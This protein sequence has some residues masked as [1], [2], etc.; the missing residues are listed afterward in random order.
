M[1]TRVNVNKHT[2]VLLLG[3]ADNNR[4]RKEIVYANKL[5]DVKRIFG[6]SSEL[7]KAYQE[8]SLL[9]APAIFL[10]NC[11]EN[12]DYLEITE[13]LRANDF[14]YIVP[15]SLNLSDE[16]DEPK[17]E[18]RISYIEYMLEQIGHINESVFIVTD[19]HADLYEDMDAFI[20]SMNDIAVSFQQKIE[21]AINPENIIFVANNLVNYEHANIPLV[22]SLVI[23]K[24]NQY[25]VLDFGPALFEID[26]FEDIG[27][28]AYFQNHVVRSTTVENLLNFR[29]IS[30]TKI[31]FI[32]RICKIIKRQLNFNE[33]IGR[34]YT[35]YRRLGVETKLNTYLTALLKELIYDYN[36]ISVRGYRSPEPLSVNIENVFE[37][38]PVNCLEKV[39][40]SNTVEVA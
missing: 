33:F 28:W 13:I 37:I 36:I 20:E 14:A 8:L 21:P 10:C 29:S 23:T 5:N 39:T 22:A 3:K 12:Y 25:P 35:E 38:W 24:P 40:I 32:S 26:Q 7:T 11:R 19:K 16:F 17:T 9:G 34:Q 30:P 2:S 6:D 27:N 18:R 15:V 31:V 1:A 4:Y